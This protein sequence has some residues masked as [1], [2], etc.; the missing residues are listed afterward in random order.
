M[1]SRRDRAAVAQRGFTILELLVVISIIA[2]ATAGLLTNKLGG[3]PVFPP[4]PKAV[5]DYNFN[6]PGYWTPA[7][8]P[9]RY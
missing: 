3:P 6:R 7:T 4:V 5:L 8:G 2:L 1:R 9:D